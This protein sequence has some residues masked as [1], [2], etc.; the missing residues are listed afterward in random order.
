MYR[1]VIQRHWRRATLKSKQR[2]FNDR[3]SR[4]CRW[5]FQFFT[6]AVHGLSWD[7]S[8]VAL[9]RTIIVELS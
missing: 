4:S 9:K 5:E 6:S 8:I 2:S 3:K 1:Y 7:E